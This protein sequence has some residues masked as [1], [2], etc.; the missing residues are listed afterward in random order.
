VGFDPAMAG[1]P[2]AK[3]LEEHGEG[4]RVVMKAD[5]LIAVMNA[6]AMGIGLGV[7]PCFLESAD[8]NLVRVDDR[9]LGSRTAWLVAHPDVARIPRVRT[10][11]EFVVEM[12]KEE[13]TILSGEAPT[14]A[15]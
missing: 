5:S 9:V 14:T 7:L 10:V 11:I 12:M 2:G 13:A 1:V 3:W 8:A 6:T 4:T 15:A